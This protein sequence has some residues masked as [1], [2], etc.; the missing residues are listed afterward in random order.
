M[1]CSSTS[2]GLS[3]STC[4]SAAAPAGLHQGLVSKALLGFALFI[5]AALP[6]AGAKPDQGDPK[7]VSRPSQEL[8]SVHH[9]APLL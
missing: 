4:G 6:T 5:S 8:T 1:K 9:S 2:K 7:A 3:H